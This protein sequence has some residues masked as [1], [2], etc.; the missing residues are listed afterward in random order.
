MKKQTVPK[1]EEPVTPALPDQPEVVL[2]AQ[3]EQS[4]DEHAVENLSEN[5]AEHLV[6]IS[7]EE[8]AENQRS[9]KL[10]SWLPG[11]LLVIIL[12]G[13]G[14][15]AYRWIVVRP[16]LQAQQK[17]VTAPVERR[18]LTLI[19]AAN[20]TIQ[21]QRSI[22]LSPKEPGRL[23]TLLVKEGDTVVQGQVLAFMDD[24][25]LQGQKTQAAGQ[26]AAARANL[27]KLR[28]GNRPQ[29]IAQAQA[30]LRDAQVTLR[31]SNDDLQR[32]QEIFQQGAISRQDFNQSLKERDS[33]QARVV[34]AQQALSLLQVGARPE[35]IAQA[36]AQVLQ[37]QGVLQD[38]QTKISDRVI[39]AP[40]TGVVSRKFADPGAFVTP[41]T[42]GSA[43]ASATSSSILS[44]AATNQ[45]VADV[46]ESNIAQI[47]RGQKVMFQADAYP[48][49]TFV[50]EVSE[51][52]VESTL[53]QNVT[54]F[55]V[56]ARILSPAAQL[57]SG[58]NVDATFQAGQVPN[59]LVV[60]TVAITR[61]PQETGVFVLA[62]DRQPLFKPITTGVTVG[63]K[64]EVKS[65]LAGKEQVLITFPPGFR[66]RT[67]P[68]SPFGGTPRR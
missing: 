65:G 35:E 46:A 57:R 66:P 33:A 49:K 13:T 42:A 55:E 26:L 50:A 48:G 44:L 45:V 3:V 41:T 59:V 32:N 39:R 63:D 34:E 37:Q 6:E 62:G 19:V 15:A 52:A 22:N 54:S 58:M 21:P 29:D 1:V 7:S 67:E 17:L 5:L 30:R 31:Q 64:T 10:L 20:G 16:R 56:K 51:I 8:L 4:S 28:A 11:I 2:A 14:L 38:V 60:P 43:V 24:A 18:T 47:H 9:Q 25:D 68:R 61:Q 53:E 12:A 23:K 40:F 27:E 36:Q